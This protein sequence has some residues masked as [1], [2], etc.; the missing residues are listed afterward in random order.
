MTGD[1]RA[2]GS[3]AGSDAPR[4]FFLEDRGGRIR[5]RRRGDALSALADNLLFIVA[6]ALLGAVI[7]MLYAA[8]IPETGMM[9]G[10]LEIA[11]LA[12]LVMLVAYIV[13]FL[14]RMLGVVD[15]PRWVEVD[16]EH[17]RVGSKRYPSR[18]GRFQ[19]GAVSRPAVPEPA[20]TSGKFRLFPARIY[21]FYEGGR[22]IDTT[23]RSRN[24]ADLHSIADT[25]NGRLPRPATV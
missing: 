12:W 11:T 5:V 4:G 1:E 8:R 13:Y 6:F 25:L 19:I 2:H 16:E 9:A 15:R 24:L 7:F 20:P 10:A 17:V 18:E 14:F 21:L 3:I 23:L 22:R